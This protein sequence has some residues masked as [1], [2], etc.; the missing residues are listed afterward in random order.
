[1][2]P[3]PNTFG[4]R[5]SCRR[6]IDVQGENVPLPIESNRFCVGEG[7][8]VLWT[9]D[10]DGVLIRPCDRSVEILDENDGVVLVR[11]GGGMLWRE[12]VSRAVDWGL[13]GLENLA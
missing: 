12:W 13:H 7:S 4:V 9:D 11:V 2:I 10:F 3:I 5:A 1:M 8:N 6:I